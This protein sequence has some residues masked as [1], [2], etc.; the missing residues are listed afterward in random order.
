M[1]DSSSTPRSLDLGPST[2][3]D[4]MPGFL[5]MMNKLVATPN[6]SKAHTTL[7]P[8]LKLTDKDLGF[9][10]ISRHP[11]YDVEA[12]LIL[13]GVLEKH[14]IAPPNGGLPRVWSH[15]KKSE[16]REIARL[17]K[18]EGWKRCGGLVARPT[19]FKAQGE[20]IWEG[21]GMFRVS[22][23]EGEA[24]GAAR[25]WRC[26]TEVPARLA[27]CKTC[28]RGFW[29]RLRDCGNV[30]KEGEIRA[31][32]AGWERKKYG[33][34][35]GCMPVIEEEDGE[36]GARDGA[37]GKGGIKENGGLNDSGVCLVDNSRQT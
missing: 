29:K 11:D 22:E 23:R 26:F 35:V 21:L 8:R 17:P 16:L 9:T 5:D 30:E 28:R 12:S 24:M 14:N 36:D 10:P 27:G 4:H 33:R 7:R 3:F 37:G 13:G 18:K 25:G 20:R 32:M 6:P 34:I 2:L 1:S 31:G 19:L 15:P